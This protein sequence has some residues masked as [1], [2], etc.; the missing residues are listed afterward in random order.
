MALRK[1]DPLFVALFMVVLTAAIVPRFALAET[2]NTR[3]QLVPRDFRAPD[4]VLVRFTLE[5]VTVVGPGITVEGKAVP[6]NTVLIGLIDKD[7]K[8]LAEPEFVEFIAPD[9][10]VFFL[11]RW[12]D[13]GLTRVRLDGSEPPAPLDLREVKWPV[14]NERNNNHGLVDTGPGKRPTVVVFDDDWREGFRL[15]DVDKMVV[16]PELQHVSY[17]LHQ[18]WPVERLAGG[19]V[20]AHHVDPDGK[21]YSRFYDLRGNPLGPPLPQLFRIPTSETSR[22]YVFPTADRLFWPISHSGSPEPLPKEVLGVIPLV[23][24]AQ[25]YLSYLDRVE[26]WAIKAQTRNGVRWG[27]VPALD[28]LLER[29][30]EAV[31]LAFD[32]LSPADDA[33]QKWN[34][35]H[36]SLR[37]PLLVL[38][39]AGSPRFALFAYLTKGAGLVRI[40]PEL[41]FAE[42]AEAWAWVHTVSQTREQVFRAEVKQ[43]QE[44]EAVA[45]S[46][47]RAAEKTRKLA[48]FEELARRSFVAPESA[49]LARELGGNHFA[50]WCL[51]RTDLCTNPG[52]VDMALARMDPR[53]NEYTALRQHLDR[54]A[55]P[56]PPRRRGFRVGDLVGTEGPKDTSFDGY[57]KGW[58][59]WYYKDGQLIVVPR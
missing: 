45:K 37:D 6:P 50:R 49:A 29:G 19:D 34:P 56:P 11:R 38:R 36:F 30:I 13:R 7:G 53:T 9:S 32:A 48:R 46:H 31:D 35:F 5:Q 25:W 27:L 26:G 4:K 22:R 43:R 57:R 20:L 3:V 44:A 18:D 10:K 23:S 54:I 51:V 12:S 1:L 15:D 24:R 41:D 59:N 28:G 58:Q 33:P 2:P 21:R 55:P 16:P 14:T 39:P 8:R 42:P 40:M 52:E 47:A 17:N